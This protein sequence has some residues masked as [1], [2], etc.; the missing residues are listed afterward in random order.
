M[1]G[2]VPTPLGV[3]SVL[4]DDAHRLTAIGVAE[5]PLWLDRPEAA[6][7]AVGPALA[8]LAEYAVGK[9]LTFD[10]PL[11]PGGTPFQ[12]RVW[13]ALCEIPLGETRNY[14]QLA[15]AIGQP[16]AARAVGAANGRNPLAVVVPCHRVIGAAGQLVGYAGGLSFKRRLL[17]HE[18]AVMAR[19]GVFAPALA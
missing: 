1:R 13:A 3:F 2:H 7:H 18:A 9:R 11:A 15:A 14:G 6:A 4:L 10:L 16:S 17:D 5:E 19:R 12:Q 8:Q